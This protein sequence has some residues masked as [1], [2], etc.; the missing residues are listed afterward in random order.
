MGDSVLLMVDANEGPMRRPLRTQRSLKLGT[1]H[2]GGQQGGSPPLG[3]SRGA[4]QDLDLFW[5]WAPPTSR[6]ISPWSTVRRWRADRRDPDKDAHQ[7][8]EALFETIVSEVPPPKVNLAAPFRMQVSTLAWSDYLGRIG[9]GRVLEGSHRRGDELVR[10]STRWTGEGRGPDDWEIVGLDN[11]RSSHLY[12]TRGLEREEVEEVQAGDIVWM[13]GPADITIGDTLQAPERGSEALPPLEIEEPTVSMFFLVTAVPG[14]RRRPGVTLGSQGPAEREPRVTWPCAWR[15]SA[16]GWAQGSGRG[17]L[18]WAS[19]S[20]RCGARAR[21][22]ACR[23]GRSSPS[24]HGGRCWS[25]G[26]TTWTCRRNTRC[27]DREGG[28]RR[29]SSPVCISGSAWCGGVRIPTRG[30]WLRNE[31]SPTLG[32][33]PQSSRFEGYGPWCGAVSRRDRGSLSDGIRPG[34]A[35]PGELR[36]RGQVRVTPDQVYAGMIMESIRVRRSG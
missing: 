22:C 28:Q 9:C 18:H 12:V 25:H 26:E 13:V 11:A 24:G 19:S 34:P 16:G 10:V 5:S 32:A 31:S 33:G 23:A 35:T 2:C 36:A 15:T 8:M 4:G 1:A 17:A 30:L 27:G 14:R 20:R 29:A 21:N 3:P 6:P 7:G